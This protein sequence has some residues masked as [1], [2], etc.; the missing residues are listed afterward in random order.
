M[1]KGHE[2]LL[3]HL[4]PKKLEKELECENGLVWVEVAEN[5][6][7]AMAVCLCSLLSLLSLQPAQP[8]VGESYSRDGEVGF[9]RLLILYSK[10]CSKWEKIGLSVSHPSTGTV[11]LPNNQRYFWPNGP[12]W[13]IKS[14]CDTNFERDYTH[15]LVIKMTDLTIISKSCLKIGKIISN[16]FT[17][18][19]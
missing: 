18:S 6:E 12:V 14:T 13:Y 15:F 2:C 17:I 16:S 9:V 5:G 1:K 19:P 11:T 10:A 4:K 3:L 8:S 7:A